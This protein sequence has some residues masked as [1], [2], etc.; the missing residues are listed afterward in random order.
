MFQASETA[1]ECA[2]AVAEGEP[3]NRLH[4]I[5]SANLVLETLKSPCLPLIPHALLRKSP[6][7]RRFPRPTMG[8]EMDE[9]E[10]LTHHLGRVLAT[11][12]GEAARL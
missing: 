10:P 6:G 4:R 9:D 8:T 11:L 5:F 3:A 12:A 1:N 2:D 7:A